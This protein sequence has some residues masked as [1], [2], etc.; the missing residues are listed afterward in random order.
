MND[1]R[2]MNK[3]FVI[4]LLV[5]AYGYLAVKITY[6]LICVRSVK[7]EPISNIFFDACKVWVLNIQSQSLV[8]IKSN[9]LK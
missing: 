2:N 4:L 9:S 3:A 6:I 8:Y 1:L 5:T 7:I